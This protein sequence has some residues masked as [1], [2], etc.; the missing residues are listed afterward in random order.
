M[1]PFRLALLLFLFSSGLQA[2]DLKVADIFSDHMV[3]QQGQAIPVWGTAAPGATVKV[4]FNGQTVGGSAGDDGRWRIDLAAES[5]TSES[6][7]FVVV[8][9]ENITVFEGVLVGE[10]WYASGQ[11]NMG[12]TMKSCV[13]KLDEAK[14]LLEEADLPQIR[15][16]AVRE[17]ENFERQDQI[18]DDKSWVVTTP[19]T[20]A[21]YSA[22]AF[23][24]ARRLHLELEIPIGIIESAWG[25]H[26]IEPFI[27]R[28]A[29]TG[30]SVLEELGKLSDARDF[31]GLKK[32]VGGVWARNDSWLC[33]TIYNSRVAPV[34]PFA[35]RGAIWYQAESNAGKGEDP[36]FYSE[37][38]QALIRG[39][40]DAWGQQLPVYWVQLPQYSS[41]GW[42][43][44]RD[45]QRRA[46]TEP[47]TGMAVTIDLALDEI[48]PANKI[49]VAERLALWPLAR[50]YG[51]ELAP[52]GPT[53]QS[54][55][56]KGSE[57]VV[58]FE[59]FGSELATGRKV[60]LAP[61]KIL[62]GRDV[63]GFEI[64]GANGIWKPAAARIE[65]DAVFCTSP[66][67]DT[68]VAIRYGWAPTMPAAKPWNLYNRA[69]LP[70]SPFISHP[71]LA[72]YEPEVVE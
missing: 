38:M 58:R 16:R 48:H 11:S 41:P 53:F 35:I 1:T 62:E 56:V 59:A 28:S 66:E 52:G 68:P 45:E 24:F 20:A 3:L 54:I 64:T 4:T 26:P 33:E 5:A 47:K 12:M 30:S 50:E 7:N 61:T 18:G 44:M 34:V 57:I 60:D 6:R 31:A 15:Y 69:G 22:V 51:R 32:L 39:W 55:A 72:P 13:G 46:L 67:I 63:H 36:R 2:E 8:S 17:K 70:A 65:D 21:S 37:K 19:E 14:T 42:V 23:L 71:E 43:S 27:P 49:D 29:F 10:V 25:G 40:R 9:G